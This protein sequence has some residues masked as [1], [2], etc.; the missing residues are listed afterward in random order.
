MVVTV[1]FVIVAAGVHLLTQNILIC[2]GRS[3]CMLER[4]KNVHDGCPNRGHCKKD[5]SKC[6]YLLSDKHCYL[7]SKESEMFL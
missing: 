5:E 1:M 6:C 3:Y 2:H 7:D 4:N